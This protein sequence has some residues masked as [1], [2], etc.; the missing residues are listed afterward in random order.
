MVYR[1]VAPFVAF[2]VS[3]VAVVILTPVFGRLGARFGLVD[4]PRAGELQREPTARSGGYAMIA[5][6]LIAVLVSLAWVPRDPGETTH[7][8]GLIAGVLLL[9]PLALVDDF[10]RLGPLPQLVGQI[11][12]AAVA[13]ASGLMIRSVADPFGGL[14]ELPVLVAVPF[15]L[16]WII[17]TVNTVNVIDTMDGLAAG[18]SAIAALVLFARSLTLGQDTID[19]L[20]IALAGV[21][22]GFLGFNFHPA[23][24][25]MGSS[26][27]MFLGFT[28]ATLSIIGGA[29]IAT[30][31][32]VL[33]LPIIDF[34]A[35]IIQR[36]VSRR[37]PMIGGDNA[38]LPHRLIR[39]GMSTRRITLSI[40][41]VSAVC[42]AMALTFTGVQKLAVMTVAAVVTVVVALRSATGQSHELPRAGIRD[43]S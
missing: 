7:L 43:L 4:R 28:L 8:P 2:A 36:S 19:T 1:L 33:G 21:C 39:K 6:F 34:A 15:T 29:K 27:S 26:G 40:Y 9:I 11:G 5:S 30:A 41:A 17:G 32:F 16:L 13:M 35:V 38:H 23:R 31:A 22:V 25:F 18:I 37:S 20:P 14:I 12:I 24:I 3:L 42:G 10:K